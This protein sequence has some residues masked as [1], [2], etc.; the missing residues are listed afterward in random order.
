MR[1][2]E[3]EEEEIFVAKQNLFHIEDEFNGTYFHLYLQCYKSWNIK[4]RETNSNFSREKIQ[5]VNY[6]IHFLI[7]FVANVRHWRLSRL[8]WK[9]RHFL[10]FCISLNNF[11]SNQL[12]CHAVLCRINV[13]SV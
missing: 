7:A 2:K 1:M 4:I 3:E 13:L 8:V 5:K 9:S 10:C 6:V 12:K 11:I